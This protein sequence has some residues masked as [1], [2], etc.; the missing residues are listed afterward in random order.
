MPARDRIRSVFLTCCRSVCACMHV[1]DAGAHDHITVISIARR[2]ANTCNRERHTSRRVLGYLAQ[3]SLA[4]ALVHWG[5]NTT[6]V[7]HDDQISALRCTEPNRL[8]RRTFAGLGDTDDPVPSPSRHGRLLED[9]RRSPN[10]SKPPR[11]SRHAVTSARDRLFRGV[12]VESSNTGIVDDHRPVVLLATPDNGSHEGK[13]KVERAHEGNERMQPSEDL[14]L[15]RVTT[16]DRDR[17]A[18]LAHCGAPLRCCAAI[19][20]SRAARRWSSSTSF[21]LRTVM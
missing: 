1:H 5:R 6:T 13:S 18:A 19:S 21:G 15:R 16:T 11:F 8:T 7:R 10:T 20:R 9:E 12:D 17:N 2:A 3:T 4:R 14:F